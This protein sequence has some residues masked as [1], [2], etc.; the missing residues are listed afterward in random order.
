MIARQLCGLVAQSRACLEADCSFALVR[1][2]VQASN[3]TKRKK[4]TDYLSRAARS[5]RTHKL[6]CK[7]NGNQ[8]TLPLPSPLGRT[9]TRGVCKH[10]EERV[11]ER[12]EDEYKSCEPLTT[13][14]IPQESGGKKDAGSSRNSST[15]SSCAGTWTVKEQDISKEGCP[16]VLPRFGSRPEANTSG[17]TNRT[18]GGTS[19]AKRVARDNP[20][21]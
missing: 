6:C 5:A 14:V 8:G 11:G 12:E 18:T 2:R 16:G 21:D 13:N 7:K 10:Q 3:N 4:G 19:T 20:L 1:Q 15:K 9:A 17:K